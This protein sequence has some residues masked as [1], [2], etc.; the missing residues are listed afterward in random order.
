MCAILSIRI[1]GVFETLLVVV[2]S[3]KIY[4]QSVN[5]LFTIYTTT[6]FIT[7]R[8]SSQTIF[9]PLESRVHP[10]ILYSIKRSNITEIKDAWILSLFSRKQA[11]LSD[12]FEAKIKPAFASEILPQPSTSLLTFSSSLKKEREKQRQPEESKNLQ[13]FAFN[14]RQV[15]E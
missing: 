1:I 12:Q 11:F 9:H 5:A 3:K 7:R 8:F 15:L 14:E 13:V 2:R 10:Q 4:L 6:S